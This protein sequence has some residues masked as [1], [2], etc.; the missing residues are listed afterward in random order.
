MS[1]D[2][3]TLLCAAER[4]TEELLEAFDR[5]AATAEA[6]LDTIEQR[7]QL[8]RQIDPGLART[9][10]DLDAALRLSDLD[11]RL[12]IAIDDRRR[13]V[14][15]QLANARRRNVSQPPSPRLVT[16]SA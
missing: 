3:H 6:I 1:A 5:D 9:P 12:A 8:L 2:T 4:L 7:E 11:R 10:A 13:V 16:E 15:T 14:A